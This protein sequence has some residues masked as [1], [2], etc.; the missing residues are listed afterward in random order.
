MIF[1]IEMKLIK[2]IHVLSNKIDESF[3][4]FNES[5]SVRIKLDK[6]SL[7]VIDN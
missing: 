5:E 6:M 4:N 3:F 7:A 1:S 2:F